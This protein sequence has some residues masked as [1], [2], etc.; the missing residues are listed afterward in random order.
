MEE[1]EIETEKKTTST[2]KVPKSGKNVTDLIKE[3]GNGDEEKEQET[4][5]TKR[6]AEDAELSDTTTAKKTKNIV[7]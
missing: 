6:K 3:E 2:S 7:R 1:M 5:G 4:T